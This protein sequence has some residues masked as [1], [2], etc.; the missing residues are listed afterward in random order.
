M[1]LLFNSDLVRS[2]LE[3]M[4]ESKE[5]KESIEIPSISAGFKSLYTAWHN[6]MKGIHCSRPLVVVIDSI[7]QLNDDSNGRSNLDWIPDRLP[8]NVWLIVST[9][10][11]VSMHSQLRERS[12]SSTI[13]R[14]GN[15]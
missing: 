3:Q 1:L 10:P 12:K 5:K 15:P 13:L 2:I 11:Q 7:D 14:K 8:G 9:L 6:A 4:K